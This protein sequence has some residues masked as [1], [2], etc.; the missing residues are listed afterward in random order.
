VVQH[1]QG[2]RLPDEV[3]F[4]TVFRNAGFRSAP[5]LHY[6]SPFEQSHPRTIGPDELAAAQASGR[7]F[8]RKFS[9]D[10]NDPTRRVVVEQVIG[11]N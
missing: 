6:V 4:A 2:L 7:L 8:A 1:F 5:S 3:L 9:T 11:T 10:Q